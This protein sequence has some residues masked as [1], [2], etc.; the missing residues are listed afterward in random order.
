MGVVLVEI[1]DC[2]NEVEQGNKEGSYEQIFF[3]TGK[4]KY[5]C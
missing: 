1:N 2:D 4:T 3:T 5:R